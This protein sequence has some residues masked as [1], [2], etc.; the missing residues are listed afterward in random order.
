MGRS[1]SSMGE[2]GAQ[3]AEQL[4]APRQRRQHRPPT[5]V[6]YRTHTGT[7]HR[8]Q[9]RRRPA[10]NAA[11][12][13]PHH[14]QTRNQRDRDRC[15]AQR[16]DTISGASSSSSFGVSEYPTRPDRYGDRPDRIS[17]RL[18][19]NR[20]GDKSPYPPIPPLYATVGRASLILGRQRTPQ[21]PARTIIDCARY[22]DGYRQG[23]GRSR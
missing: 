22:R 5:A 19:A 14:P 6:A 18:L 15:T 16:D 11:G 21:K 2:T 1:T 17:C 4:R 20:L 10:Q 8:A 9:D 13:S 3:V 23:M 12:H 7:D